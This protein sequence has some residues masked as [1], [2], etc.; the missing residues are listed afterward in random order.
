ML[1]KPTKVWGV[2]GSRMAVLDLAGVTVVE[3]EDMG[4]DF[5]VL[6]C[7]RVESLDQFILVEGGP[8]SGKDSFIGGLIEVEL[9]SKLRITALE[10]PAS[11]R[12]QVLYYITKSI[13]PRILL[14]RAIISINHKLRD[15]NIDNLLPRPFR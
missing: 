14:C 7:Q 1:G 6:D 5:Q 11:L 10:L 4:L 12:G 9:W 15:I 3:K 2:D 8:A 13:V